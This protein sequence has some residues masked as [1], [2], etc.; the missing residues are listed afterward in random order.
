[1][2]LAAKLVAVVALLALAALNRLLTP[3]AAAGDS[4]AARRLAGSIVFELAIVVVILGLV[5]SWRFTPPPRSLL[6]AA[7]QPVLA[8]IHAEKAMADLR[9]EPA[10]AAGRSVIIGLLDG[11]FRPL[12]AKEVVLVLWKPDAGIEPLRLPATHQGETTWR[13]EGVR[14][15]LAGRWRARVEILVS[16]FEKI[17]LED[18]IELH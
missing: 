8:H 6:A 12:A 9:I 13:I 7:A 14:L 10:G 5:A 18:E 17:F 3:R 15:P 11:E 16:D 2:L 4:R 1:V